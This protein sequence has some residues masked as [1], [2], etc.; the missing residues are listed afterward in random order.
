MK[1]LFHNPVKLELTLEQH[2]VEL[3]ASTFHLGAGV[4]Q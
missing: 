4:L 3:L 2:A 1:Q